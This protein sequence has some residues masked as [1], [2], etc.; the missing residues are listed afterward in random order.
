M[1][2]CRGAVNFEEHGTDKTRCKELR[3]DVQTLIK[4]REDWKFSPTVWYLIHLDVIKKSEAGCN[5][6]PSLSKHSDPEWREMWREEGVRF[7]YR[8]RNVCMNRDKIFKLETNWRQNFFKDSMKLLFFKKKDR[9]YFS[10]WNFSVWPRV[11]KTTFCPC[12]R[13]IYKSE[14]ISTWLLKSSQGL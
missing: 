5:L 14:M 1:R 6:D 10:L 11:I 7:K 9:S 12:F 8:L 3:S 4:Q 2:S 13:L